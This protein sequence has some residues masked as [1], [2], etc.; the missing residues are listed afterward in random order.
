MC[1][2][3]GVFSGHVLNE[4]GLVLNPSEGLCCQPEKAAAD[5]EHPAEE[6]GEALGFPQGFPQRQRG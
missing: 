3:Y 1:S 4:W 5:R 6:Q 2:R